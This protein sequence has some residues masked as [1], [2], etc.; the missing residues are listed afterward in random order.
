MGTP[1]G[2][3]GA[4][5]APA[6]GLGGFMRAEDSKSRFVFP[7]LG[8]SWGRPEAL[9]GRLGPLLGRLGALLGRLGGLLGASWGPLGPSWD[10]V[11]GFLR[12][13]G[14]SE[15]RKREQPKNTEKHNENRQFWPPGAFLEVLLERSWGLLGHHG[16]I[17]GGLVRSRAVL[18]ASGR[19]LRAPRGGP[20][21]QGAP[22]SVQIGSPAPGTKVGCGGGG[23]V[24]EKWAAPGPGDLDARYIIYV[25]PRPHPRR[26]AVRRG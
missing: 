8:P 2:L 20:E 19:P 6:G 16:A 17:F 18:A 4:S 24:L 9:L 13:L 14:V 10:D 23:G 7:L 3:F 15:A 21:A 1:W 26:P 12:S 11:G 22:W 5:W 25:G